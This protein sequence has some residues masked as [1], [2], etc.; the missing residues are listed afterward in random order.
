MQEHEHFSARRR[1]KNLMSLYIILFLGA[2]AKLR[3]AIISFFMF[4]RMKKLGSHW[5]DLHE[6]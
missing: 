5:T 3:Q 2:F 4:V 1:E 6:I